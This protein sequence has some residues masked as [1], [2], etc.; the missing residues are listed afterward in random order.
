MILLTMGVQLPFD[1]LVRAVDVWA[2]ERGRTDVYAQIGS[3]K[4]QPQN[5]QFKH[6]ISPSE[7]SELAEKADVVVAHAGMGSIIT[8]LTLRKPI[9]VMPRRASLNEH[10]NDHQLATARHL[11]EKGIVEV[12]QDE[13][14]LI[15]KLD[16]IQKIEI[17]TAV[18]NDASLNLISTIAGF[19]HS[20]R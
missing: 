13:I 9:L 10:R 6:F 7:F 8:A 1:R 14:E 15:R 19:I 17:R 18:K 11:A 16:D 4:Y 3:T 20:P 12:A 2:G 5:L